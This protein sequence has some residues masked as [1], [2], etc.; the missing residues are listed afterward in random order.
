MS[1]TNEQAA[2]D[3]V[4]GSFR[5]TT[6]SSKL[7]IYNGEAWFEIDFTSPEQHTGATR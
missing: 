7:E 5:F 1:Q 4:S 3:L 2:R 6:D